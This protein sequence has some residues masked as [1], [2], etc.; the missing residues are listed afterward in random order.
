MEVEL[1]KP[2]QRQ[3]VQANIDGLALIGWMGYRLEG[4]GAVFIVGDIPTRGKPSVTKL[5]TLYR[6]RGCPE[7]VGQ[8]IQQYEPTTQIVVVID[9]G[10]GKSL[11]VYQV[12]HPEGD[13]PAVAERLK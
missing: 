12:D 8:L 11:N 5:S 4:R 2:A 9:Y 6:T 13:I 10:D 7:H 1:D 3:F